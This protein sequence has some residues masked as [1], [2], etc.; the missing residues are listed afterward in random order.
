MPKPA[1]AVMSPK[2]RS[3]YWTLHSSLYAKGRKPI[4]NRGSLRE[5]G[6]SKN[7]EYSD[8]DSTPL[9]NQDRGA[10]R[11]VS[12]G[13]HYKMTSL[14]KRHYKPK[15][16][17]LHTLHLRM[18]ERVQK[19]EG[20]LLAMQRKLSDMESDFKASK[21][22]RGRERERELEQS[23]VKRERHTQDAGLVEKLLAMFGIRRW[24]SMY[25]GD[26]S[27]ED[28][29]ENS[30]L[31]SRSQQR[32]DFGL[33]SLLGR[34]SSREYHDPGSVAIPPAPQAPA[35]W[36]A[37]WSRTRGRYYYVNDVTGQSVW[38]VP[39]PVPSLSGGPFGH[40][41]AAQFSSP[42]RVLNPVSSSMSPPSGVQSSPGISSIGSPGANT[43]TQL[44]TSLFMGGSSSSSASSSTMTQLPTLS[45]RE[46]AAPL[47]PVAEHTATTGNW[48]GPQDL[49]PRPG[50]S[51]MPVSSL[52]VSG[53]TPTISPH[54]SRYASKSSGE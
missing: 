9:R 15:T 25:G 8:S 17:E 32:F 26:G 7:R 34:S 30:G 47:S 23:K 3:V 43:S 28:G 36:T 27:L 51:A 16:A 46:V 41:S 35:G 2:F 22:E 18:N 19:L 20:D 49:P 54:E 44:G 40:S 31:S 29:I 38:D 37:E 14:A 12:G 24:S 53:G 45:L 42:A 1:L 33:S 21:R 5:T 6:S 10:I 39:A 13:I 11:R 52:S 50:Y 4:R 48:P